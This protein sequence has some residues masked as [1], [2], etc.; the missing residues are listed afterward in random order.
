[1]NSFTLAV[2]VFNGGLLFKETLQSIEKVFHHFNE[3]FI[4][5]TKTANYLNDLESCNS[6]NIPNIRINLFNKEGCTIH[7]INT[8]SELNTD[9][10]LFLGHDDICHEDGIIEA[11]KMLNISDTSNCVYGSNNILL[12][13]KLIKQRI[14]KEKE[15]VSISDFINLRIKSEF[16]INVSGI[17]NSVRNLKKSIPLMKLNNESYW[18]DMLAI[19]TPFT[20]YVQQTEYPITTIRMH[21][22]QMSNNVNDFT[23]YCKDG[24]WFHLIFSLSN[25]DLSFHQSTIKEVNRLGSYINN[26]VFIFYYLTLLFKIIFSSHRYNPFYFI[27]NL[28]NI[29]KMISINSK[30][31]IIIILGKLRLLGQ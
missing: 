12:N 29:M 16:Y 3:V 31:S 5:I 27:L 7:F 15:L 2:N 22:N 9:F 21:E 6:Y 13:N 4:S 17:F 19:T 14:I 11:I 26:K 24:I 25:F 28:L 1:M 8:I 10:V 30:N 18:L 23:S 20:D